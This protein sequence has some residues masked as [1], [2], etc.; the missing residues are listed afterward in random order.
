VQSIVDDAR[1]RGVAVCCGQA[2]PFERTRPFGVVAAAL[3]LSRRS[4]HAL[5]HAPT[6]IKGATV[7]HLATMRSTYER[8][9]A[10]DIAGWR[11]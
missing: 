11:G 8:I 4:P 10:G 7:D 3:D 1:S 5:T 2:H 9:N 6:T